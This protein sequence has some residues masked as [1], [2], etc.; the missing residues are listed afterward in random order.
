VDRDLGAREPRAV[1]ERGVIE[2]IG[3]DEVPRAR[4]RGQH[5][6]VGGIAARKGES[7]VGAE[8]PGQRTLEGFV[9]QPLPG[10]EARGARPQREGW[11]G[12]IGEP[13][14]VVRAQYQPGARG[15]GSRA[16]EEPLV[17]KP[18]Q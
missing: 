2:P 6:Y 9:L 14:I 16:T 1:D 10:D 15:S 8:P 18:S 5:A 4:Q 11:T 3:E 7:A 17:F 12:T 13:E